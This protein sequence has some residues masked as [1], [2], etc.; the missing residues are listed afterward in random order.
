[1]LWTMGKGSRFDVASQSA[2]PGGPASSEARVIELS[3]DSVSVRVDGLLAIIDADDSIIQPAHD[4]IERAFARG[5][6]ADSIIPGEEAAYVARV[7]GQVRSTT[8]EGELSVSL[9][10]YMKN[11]V[12]AGAI[13]GASAYLSTDG[14]LTNMVAEA[15]PPSGD[16]DVRV[17]T[18]RIAANQTIVLMGGEVARHVSDKELRQ[19]VQASFSNADAA[20]WLVTLAASRSGRTS[21]ALLAERLSG[22]PQARA[23]AEPKKTGKRSGF[24]AARSSRLGALAVVAGLIIIAGV[25]L[26]PGLMNRMQPS[27]SASAYQ[28]P[29][30][31][32]VVTNAASTNGKASAQLQWNAVPGVSSYLVS[33]GGHSYH[34]SAPNLQV[35]DALVPGTR[36][37]WTVEAIYG[38]TKKASKPAQLVAA[39]EPPMPKPAIIRPGATLPATEASTASFCWTANRTAVSFHLYI[40]GGT[41]HL[42][43]TIPKTATIA[44]KPVGRCVH[45]A[46]TP[47]KTYAWRLGAVTPMHIQSW[48]AWQHVAVPA[49]ATTT[50][51][52]L[53]TPTSTVATSS[54]TG[55]TLNTT[56]TQVPNST[57]YQQPA[58]TQPATTSQQP[59]TVPQQPATTTQQPATTTQ[60]P[61]TSPSTSQAPS[62]S[63]TGTSSSPVL[64]CTNPPNC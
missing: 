46:L 57:G 9:A 7:L 3:G 50:T 6:D 12:I 1:M 43:R 38:K 4:T 32:S 29:T 23:A 37:T 62:S 60:Q 49:A 14:V 27:G 15:G 21:S 19:T 30:G 54:S 64:A 59:A 36:Y 51:N 17:S 52:P 8:S 2:S 10:V 63:S 34:S 31:L 58:T 25:A 45:Q 35:T 26:G 16:D 55:S 5:G 18:A 39:L 28:S 42:R 48:T 24:L 13:G 11:E 20:A 56:P 47:G 22:K 40:S 44:L 41:L 53:A 61:A 33:I